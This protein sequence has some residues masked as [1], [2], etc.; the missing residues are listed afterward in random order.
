MLFVKIIFLGP[1]RLGKTTAR[2]RLMGEIVDISS[3]TEPEQ[4]STGAV[5]SGGNVVVRNIS[6]TTAVMT[7]SEWSVLKDLTEEARTLLQ[8]IYSHNLELKELA[9][10]CTLKSLLRKIRLF[11]KFQ[12]LKSDQ[13]KKILYLLK[14]FHIHK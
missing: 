11:K 9:K 3:A 6:N 1:P 13:M 8:F 4:P 14:Q 2:R 7:P 12:I 10:K 5:E